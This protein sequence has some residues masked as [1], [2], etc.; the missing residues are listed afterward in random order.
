ML[1]RQLMRVLDSLPQSGKCPVCE[2]ESRNRCT[3]C[4]KIFYCTVDHQKQD[5]KNHKATCTPFASTIPQWTVNQLDECVKKDTV[6]DTG[7]ARRDY[8]F[9]N[10]KDE[11]EE[12]KLLKLYAGLITSTKRDLVRLHEACVTGKL[13]ELIISEYE[14]RGE[15]SEHYDWFKENPDVVKNQHPIP[16]PIPSASATE[17]VASSSGTSVAA[18]TSST[19][20]TGE[21]SS[22]TTTGFKAESEVDDIKVDQ[23]D[24]VEAP[25]DAGAGTEPMPEAVRAEPNA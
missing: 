9:V 15:K 19:S 12:Q 13:K 16:I 2:T 20:T 7:E 14:K 22:S 1:Q 25:A 6:P 23:V 5:W 8:G 18:T 4:K 17:P 21:S 3:R 11:A 10:C 24:Q